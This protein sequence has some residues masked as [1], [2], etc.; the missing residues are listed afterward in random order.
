MCCIDLRGSCVSWIDGILNC[1][2]IIVKVNMPF[3]GSSPTSSSK[4]SP[5]EA[6]IVLTTRFRGTR[7]KSVILSAGRVLI[8]LTTRFRG[9][10]SKSVVLSAGRV[11]IL[12]GFR[13]F[14]NFE[15]EK[16]RNRKIR[17]L[18]LKIP[19]ENQYHPFDGWY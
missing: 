7:S 9:T 16:K 2:F 13:A 15:T 18:Q 6:F 8:V 12:C 4:A 5:R 1:A 14:F 11:L 19:T 17:K 3:V 10:R